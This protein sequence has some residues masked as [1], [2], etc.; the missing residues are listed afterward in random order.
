MRKKSTAFMTETTVTHGE[1]YGNS[2]LETY[3]DGRQILTIA[4]KPIFRRAGFESISFEQKQGADSQ[5]DLL[6][7]HPTDAPWEEYINADNINRSRRRAVAKFRKIAL[8]NNFRYFVTLTLDKAVIDRYDLGAAVKNMNT[9]FSNRVSRKGLQYAIVP[10]QHEDGAYHFH[11]FFNDALDMADSGTLRLQGKKKPRRPRSKAQRQEWLDDGAAVVYNIP[12]W[13][14]GFSTAIELYG[15]RQKSASYCCKYITKAG[16]K[17][18]GR[19]YFSGGGLRLPTVEV[20]DLVTDF[21]EKDGAFVYDIPAID[22]QCKVFE[23]RGD[24]DT[25]G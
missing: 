17:L 19:W 18:G 2:R 14:F 11:G 7:T 24:T 8:C 13:K 16:E 20:L 21:G 5:M 4:S 23:Y 10:E 1:V 15:D 12:D 9:W 22:C 25:R 6:L 3:P